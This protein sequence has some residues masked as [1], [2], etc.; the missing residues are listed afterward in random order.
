MF[1]TI[2]TAFGT[3]TAV[4]TE[5][6]LVPIVTHQ[7]G[8]LT[9]GQKIALG[10]GIP[11]F[12]LLALGIGFVVFHVRRN[13]IRSQVAAFSKQNTSLFPILSSHFF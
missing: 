6:V 13:R 3:E 7:K 11:A 5:P 1:T 10:I 2:S 4:V 12:V 8:K 9:L